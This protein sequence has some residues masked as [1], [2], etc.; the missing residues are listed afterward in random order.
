[1]N[2][3]VRLVAAGTL[4]LGSLSAPAR[5]SIEPPEPETPLAEEQRTLLA[6]IAELPT[7]R[8]GRG[9]AESRAGLRATE[10]WAGQK[11]RDLGYDPI[12]EPVPWAPRRNWRPMDWPGPDDTPEPPFRNVYADLIGTTHPGEMIVVGAHLDAVVGSPGADDNGTGVAAVLELA[13]RLQLDPPPRTVRFVLFTL[14]EVGLVGARIHAA[15]LLDQDGDAGP[16]RVLAALSLDMLGYYTDEP[17]SQQTPFPSIPGVFEP[18]DIGNTLVLVSTRRYAALT[19]RMERAMLAASPEPIPFRV[20]FSPIPLPDLMRSDHAPFAL[21][22]VPAVMVTDTANFR[23]P[24][25][26]RESDTIDTLDARRF[27]LAVRQMEAAVRD[28]ADPAGDDAQE[29]KGVGLPNR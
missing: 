19:A 3:S 17:G 13:R 4:A 27:A 18:S 1:M 24:H 20:D 26:H 15:N 28:L 7:A 2:R 9:N 25:Y 23:S 12:F 22:G 6:L 5:A 16:R 11:L 29:P 10:D 14:E 8:A 21:R